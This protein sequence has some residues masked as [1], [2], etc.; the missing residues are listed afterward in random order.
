M[1][2]APSPRRVGLTSEP[3]GPPCRST[4]SIFAALPALLLTVTSTAPARAANDAARVEAERLVAAAAQ[5]EIAGDPARHLSLLH[6]AVG[7]DPDNKLARWQLGEMQVDG[8]WLPI[9][10]AQH[11]AATDPL[12]GEYRQLRDTA[13]KTLEDQLAV[14]RWCRKNKLD[15]EAK[16]HWAAALSLDSQNDE[17][18]RALDLHWKDGQLVTRGQAAHLKQQAQQAKDAAKHWEP[19]IAKWRRAIA[20]RDV[21]AHDAA[22]DKIR[23]IDR[24]DAIPSIEDVTLGRDAFNLKHAEECL[25][26]SVAFIEALDK[27]PEYTAAQSLVRHAVLSP[28]NKAR[29]LATAALK[30][31]PQSDF[32]PSLL[33]GLSMPIESNYNVSTD[34]DGNLRYT[35]SLYQEGANS[36]IAVDANYATIRH[37]LPGRDLAYS[38]R[39]EIWEDRTAI[40]LGT[41]VRQQQ[42]QYGRTIAVVESEVARSNRASEELSAR[43]IPVLTCTTGKEFTLANQWWDW[44]RDN[45]EYYGEDRP[46]D[47]RYFSGTDNRYYGQWYDTVRINPSCFVKGTLIWTKTGKKPIETLRLGDLILSQDI[48]SGEL[49]YRPLVYR[50]VRP[51]SPIVDLSLEKEHIL[52]TKGHPFWVAGVGWRMAKELGDDAVLHGVSGASRI[53]SITPAK[54]AEAYNLVVADFNTYFVGDSGILVH[55]NTPRQAAQLVV[56]GVAVQ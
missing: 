23:A 14:A 20:G 39:R 28:G 30:R 7:S 19:M 18:Q 17:A 54:D 15:I 56:P 24:L 29:A 31:R 13:G 11:R 12:Q 8:K 46:V 1:K 45:N 55:D 25:Q 35:H 37:V 42:L 16:V 38:T 27:M 49:G 52:A 48:N 6:E 4:I 51:P 47:Q 26:I 32:V 5:A 41:S 40:E 2:S 53:K 10:E 3:T 21:S 33:A 22:L 50:T 44:W 34:A 43:V 36:D 9:E